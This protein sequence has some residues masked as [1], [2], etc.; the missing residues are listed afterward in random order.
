MATLALPVNHTV[1]EQEEMMYLDGGH[2]II[3]LNISQ[4]VRNMASWAAGVFATGAVGIIAG[5]AV[6]RGLRMTE[7]R[8]N[9]N[10]IHWRPTITL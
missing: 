6:S 7:I 4:R 8:I 1:I 5:N 9:S 10:V 3:T 2:V